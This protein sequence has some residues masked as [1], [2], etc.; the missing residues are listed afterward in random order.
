MINYKKKSKPYAQR[1]LIKV[2]EEHF[3]AICIFF[4]S[5]S[6]LLFYLPLF[7]S[8]YMDFLFDFVAFDFEKKKENE[9]DTPADDERKCNI[10]SYFR[11]SSSS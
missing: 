9:E 10:C 3:C 8:Y 4:N 2:K 7:F 11:T 5:E 6:I 1:Q